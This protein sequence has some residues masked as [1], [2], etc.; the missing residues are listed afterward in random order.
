MNHDYRPREINSLMIITIVVPKRLHVYIHVTSLVLL[1]AEFVNRY[2]I[3]DS[4][5][6]IQKKKMLFTNWVDV[7][8]N[9]HNEIHYPTLICFQCIDSR[10]FL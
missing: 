3:L 7:R 9:E 2:D 8:L 5:F 6:L 1:A 4:K 10:N